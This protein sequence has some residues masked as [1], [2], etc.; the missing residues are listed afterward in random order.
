MKHDGN[1]ANQACPQ[2][3]MPQIEFSWLDVCKPPALILRYAWVS[4]NYNLLARTA[5]NPPPT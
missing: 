2:R 4:V 5:Q 1:G 3:S